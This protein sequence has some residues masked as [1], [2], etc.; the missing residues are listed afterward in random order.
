MGDRKWNERVTPVL[1]TAITYA[2]NLL[3][4]DSTILAKLVENDCLSTSQCEE[5]GRTVNKDGKTEAAKRLFE[6][7]KKRPDAYFD[8]FVDALQEIEQGGDLRH[9]LLTGAR[10][11]AKGERDR[12]RSEEKEAK[13]NGTVKPIKTQNFL[14]QFWRSHPFALCAI[15]FIIVSTSGVSIYI[16]MKPVAASRPTGADV[17][18]NVLVEAILSIGE[19]KWL[20]I[21]MQLGF[22]FGAGGPDRGLEGPKPMQTRRPKE[23]LERVLSAFQR[24]ERD[25]EMTRQ[26]LIDACYNVGIGKDLEKALAVSVIQRY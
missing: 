26:R 7:L 5:I 22:S 21:S 11:R 8:T 10:R 23:R 18:M 1:S 24:K 14:F 2:S 25:S 17:S 19:K 16:Q 9:L 6:T 12:E 4:P 15:L 3:G 20:Q 13:H